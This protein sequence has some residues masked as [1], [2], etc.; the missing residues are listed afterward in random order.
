MRAQLQL[1][2]TG[3]A[4]DME[5]L[6]EIRAILNDI[7]LGSKRLET[8]LTLR[9]SWFVNGTLYNSE[10]W[11]N[12]RESDLKELGVLN[13]K[14]LRCIIGAH[15][16]SPQEMLYL[17]TNVLRIPDIVSLRR[18]MYYQTVL[19]KDKNEIVRKV[20]V[21]QQNNSSKKGLGTSSTGGYKKL[22]HN[23]RSRTNYGHE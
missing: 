3:S 13:R 19:K 10:V 14:I 18:L 8:G 23:Y 6:G 4:R 9:E 20:F 5:F 17:E 2:K 12:Y 15:A 1:C 22:Q 16:K 21:A 7:P 11:C